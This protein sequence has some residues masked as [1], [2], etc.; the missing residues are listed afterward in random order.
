MV[1]GCVLCVLNDW[2]ELFLCITLVNLQRLG[3]LDE[4]AM[5]RI[6]EEII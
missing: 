6:K 1:R 5:N 2:V 3:Q 4:V